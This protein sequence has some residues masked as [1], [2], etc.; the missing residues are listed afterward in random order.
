M[1]TLST[2]AIA[3]LAFTGVVY[4]AVAQPSSAPV[5]SPAAAPSDADPGAPG[6]YAGVAPH[7][8]YD[9]N[10]RIDHLQQAI[11]ALPAGQA[12]RA[13]SQLKAIRSELKFRMSRYNGELRDWDRE[14]I[15]KKLDQ[16]V[17]QYPALQ[18]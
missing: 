1:R 3:G 8:F 4:T 15:G 5:M 6:P 7:A 13:A 16:F 18:S 9:V 17:A 14:L 11:S 10:A 2:L 12:R